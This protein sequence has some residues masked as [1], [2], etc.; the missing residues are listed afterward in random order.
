VYSNFFG[1]YLFLS[2]RRGSVLGPKENG[3]NVIMKGKE[4]T[5]VPVKLLAAVF[6]GMEVLTLL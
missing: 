1:G 5:Y 6:L 3:G 2:Q 4:A